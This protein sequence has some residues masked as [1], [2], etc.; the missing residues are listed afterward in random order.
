MPPP[1]PV[2]TSQS[3][4]ATQ[5]RAVSCT[6]LVRGAGITL[7]QMVE[8]TACLPF[9]DWADQLRVPQRLRVLVWRPGRPR[10]A[11]LADVTFFVPAYLGGAAALE[12]LTALPRLKVLQILSA[13]YEDVVPQVPAG[14]T[15]CNARGVHDASTAELAVALCLASLR[16]L[17]DAVR[18]QADRRWAHQTRPALADRRVVVVGAGAVGRAVA[19]RLAPFECGVVLVGRSARAGVTA[20][21]QLPALLPRAD[22][23]VL[24]VPLTPQTAGM[25]DAAFLAGLPDGALVV[26]VSRGQ[27]VRTGDL[28][29]ELQTGRVSAAL[30]VTDPE[31]LPA[32][33][34]LW[35]APNVLLTPHVGG[36]TT[37]FRPRADRL[38]E[39]QLHRLV[40]G[41]PLRN[42]VSIPEVAS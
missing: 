36:D 9:D 15:L 29:A 27:V 26:N 5:H 42:V 17:P 34:P 35:Q 19:R 21:G 18:A 22:V 6:S 39:D 31:P 40:D 13:G 11:G 20:V 23:V 33:H 4:V 30:D 32:E 2:W 12:P 41:R 37:A 1:S 28:L 7:P 25:V 24:A 16:G 14:V 8:H 38:V 10:P 3:L